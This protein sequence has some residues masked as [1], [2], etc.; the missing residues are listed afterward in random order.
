MS[1]CKCFW[2]SLFQGLALAGSEREKAKEQLKKLM[3]EK[4][5]LIESVEPCTDSQC[6]LSMVSKSGEK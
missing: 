5:D 6:A 4:C 2:K 3:K 1:C